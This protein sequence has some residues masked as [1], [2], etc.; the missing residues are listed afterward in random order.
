[1]T[2]SLSVIFLPGKYLR[3]FNNPGTEI[4]MNNKGIWESTSESGS[5][6]IRNVLPFTISMV[7]I[8]ILSLVII[9]LFGKRR[10]QKKLT[11][12]LIF[13]EFVSAGLLAV[14][15]FNIASDYEASLIP[16]FRL[17]I[18]PMIIFLTIMAFAGIQKDENTIRSYERLR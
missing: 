11:I 3:F 5:E 8:A 16:G 4:Y 6:L 12:A 15:G 7:G 13:L 9:F 10:L 14:Y 1:M 17:A 2:S 18:P